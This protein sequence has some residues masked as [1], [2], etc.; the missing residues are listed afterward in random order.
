MRGAGE[1]CR[2]HKW[3]NI[4]RHLLLPLAS[5]GT[6]YVTNTLNLNLYQAPHHSRTSGL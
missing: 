4:S 6:Y 3:T 5:P 2:L 1:L